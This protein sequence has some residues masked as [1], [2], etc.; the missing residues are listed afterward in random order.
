MKID[1]DFR[2]LNLTFFKKIKM[3]GYCQVKLIMPKNLDLIRSI[4]NT[5]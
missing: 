1:F 4:Q 2:I 3:F 5:K